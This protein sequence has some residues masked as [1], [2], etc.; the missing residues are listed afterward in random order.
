[1]QVWQHVIY[2]TDIE[3]LFDTLD[4]SVVEAYDRN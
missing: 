2:N 3:S 4:L 1:M